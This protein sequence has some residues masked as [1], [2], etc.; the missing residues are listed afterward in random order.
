VNTSAWVE[1]DL[2]LFSNVL[3]VLRSTESEPRLSKTSSFDILYSVDFMSEG[4]LEQVEAMEVFINDMVES[5]GCSYRKIFIREDWHK[6]APVEKKDLRE[7]L[8]QVGFYFE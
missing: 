7:Y 2:Q 8:Y 5:S 4:N 3:N 6:T 1:R